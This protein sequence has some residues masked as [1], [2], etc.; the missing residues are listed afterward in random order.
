MGRRSIVKLEKVKLPR[1][2]CAAAVDHYESAFWQGMSSAVKEKR[3][4]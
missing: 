4:G 3:K 1:E 2:D